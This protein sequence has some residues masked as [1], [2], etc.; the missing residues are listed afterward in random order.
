MKDRFM[1]GF[2][3]GVTSGVLSGA[4]DLLMVKVL[5]IGTLTFS[6]FAAIMIYG[7]KPSGFWEFAFAAFA[8]LGFVGV[9]GA[10][11]AYLVTAI[12]SKYYWVKGVVFSCAVW[13]GAYA[14]TLLYKVAP[15]KTI[16]LATAVE[17]LLLS[18][19]FGVLMAVILRWMDLRAGERV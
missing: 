3:A 4:L 14:I 15:L 13:F 12:T 2:L 11:F 18:A 9:A 10:V 5:K 8:F 1:R 19:V 16:S 7:S 6:D 17:N